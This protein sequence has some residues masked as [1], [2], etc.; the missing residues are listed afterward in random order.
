MKTDVVVIGSGISG[1]TAATL[2]ALAG[3]DVVI[4]ERRNLFGGSIRRFKRN[5]VGFDVGFHYTGCLGDGEIL[6]LLWKRCGVRDRVEVDPVFPDGYDQ[7]EFFG[8]NTVVRGYFSYARVGEEL[9]SCFP[10]EKAGI[11]SYLREIRDVC[12]QVPFYNPD[13][14]LAPFLRGYKSRPR[15]LASFLD[16]VTTDPELRSVLAAPAFLYGVPLNQ[17]S[18]ETHALVAHGYYSGAYTVKGGGQTV[19]DGFLAA[20]EKAGAKL[21]SSSKA[22][23][24]RVDGDRVAGVEIEDGK[25][26]ACSDVIFSGHPSSVP[27]MVPDSVFRP[28]YRKRLLTLKNSLSMFAVFGTAEKDFRVQAN[29]LNYYLLPEGGEM[30]SADDSTPPALRSMMIASTGGEWPEFKPSLRNGII[31]LR[32]GFWEDV[33]AFAVSRPGNRAAGYEKFKAEVGAE[34]VE[35]AE[36]RWGHFTGRIEPFAVGT[37]LTF[38][39]ELAAPGGCVYGAM[40]CLDQF[41]PDVRTRLPGLYLAGQSTLMTGVVGASIGGMTAAGEIVGLE[42]FWESLRSWC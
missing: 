24:I 27:G 35:T 37:P 25:C 33:K 23:S 5:G 26:I 3:K 17:C 22:V 21:L 40:H 41:T 32:P 29:G 38:R 11:D 7:Y 2:L 10:G 1:L 18:L 8:G 34:M 36:K 12:S 20:L 16:S 42:P 14:P 31:I 15:P 19:V 4:V 9:K 13:L 6:D 28:A 30:L 39:D